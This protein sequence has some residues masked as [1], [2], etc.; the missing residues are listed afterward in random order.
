M[1]WWKPY[2]GIS[3][4]TFL[5]TVANENWFWAAKRLSGNDTGLTGGHQAGVYLPQWFF[6]NVFP[7]ICT[8]DEY[9]PRE[10]IET[11]YFPSSD[12]LVEGVSAIYYNSRFF[13]ERGLRK[14]YNEYRLTGWGGRNASPLQDP[15]NTG[16]I[17]ILAGRRIDGRTSVLVWTCENAEDE[18][19]VESWLGRELLPSEVVGP[20]QPHAEAL[21]VAL[22]T[23][24][25]RAMLDEWMREFPTGEQIFARVQH[26]LPFETWKRGVDA[27]LQRRRELEFAIFELVEEAHLMP[28][29]SSGFGS[30][31]DFLSLALSAANRR[32]SRTGKSLELNLASIFNGL[33]I[34]FEEQVVT[35]HR[36]RPDF[37]FPGGKAYHD[38]HF[39][40]ARLHMLGAKTCCKERWRQIVTEANRI[41]TKHLF[42]LQEGVSANQLDEMLGHKVVLVVPKTNKTSF[43][44]ERRS[45]IMDLE[46][47]VQVV[48]KSQSSC[49]LFS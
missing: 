7:A 11:C 42:T 25:K 28:R 36:K 17:A 24:A 27:L 38:P 37:L 45:V 1:S 35:E 22:K 4:T 43:P 12:I 2:A 14:K 26:V 21:P 23:L 47:F 48:Q 16:A 3:L 32:K 31:S 44:K 40:A 8:T 20:R 19:I 9:N 34:Q 46:G 15:E 39:P 33:H 49:P 18:A 29:I 30:V 5:E 13:P 10:R 41:E 6:E